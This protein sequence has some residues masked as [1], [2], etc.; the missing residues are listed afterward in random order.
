MHRQRHSQQDSHKHRQYSQKYRQ[1]YQQRYWQKLWLLW[2]VLGA[3]ALICLGWMGQWGQGMAPSSLASSAPGSLYNPPRGDVRI[4]VISDLNSAYGSTDYEPE[5][6]RAIA[7]LPSLGPDVVVCGGDMVAGQ[8]RSLTTAQL[9][10]MWA[11]FD[12][13]IAAPLRR[14][15]LPFGITIGNH[16][17]SSARNAQGNFTFQPD[18]D[19]AHQYWNTPAHHPGLD[20]VDRYEFPFYYTFRQGEVFFL[21]WDGSGNRIPADKLNWV[22]SALSSPAARSAKVRIALGHLPLYG[23]AVG[24]N[25]PGEVMHQGDTLRSLLERYDVHT[26][27]SGHH[28]AYYPGHRGQL[29]LL[30]TGALGSGPRRL[31]DSDRPPIKTLTLIDVTFD[32]PDL[33]TYTTYNM[34]TL[35]PIPFTQLPRFL[36]GFNGLVLRRDLAPGDLTAAERQRCHQRLGASLCRA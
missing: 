35:A 33:T 15:G 27:I 19:L 24:R 7:L 18:R 30:H 20:F 11:A 29:Q 17:G 25:Q 1:G 8:R 3:I 16:D 4:A 2:G 6:D 5:V 12:R 23:V 32:H 36:A 31:I 26:Y 14:A 9:Q 10:A 22:E 13:H 21:V 28:H 34:A